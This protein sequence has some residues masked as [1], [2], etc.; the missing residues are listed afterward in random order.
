MTITGAA[1]IN[2]GALLS[3]NQLTTPT[4][5][6]YVLATAASGGLTSG[7]F[8][9]SG[10]LPTGYQ[11]VYN[12][13]SLDL[14]HG[15]TQT[16]TSPSPTTV[17]IITGSSTTVSATLSNTA[18][19][20]SASLTVSL[21]D[22]GSTG[23]TL[24]SFTGSGPIAAGSSTTVGA[25][26]TAGSVGTGLTW[27][28]SNTDAGAVPTT[29]STGGIVNVYNHSAAQLNVASGN[30]QSIIT[31]GAFGAATAT[32]DNTTAT[33]SVN[34]PAPLDVNTL[35]NLTGSTGSAVVGSN[36][37]G[38]YTAT[39]ALNANN[40]NVGP[41]NT[42]NVGI[43]AGDSAT[44]VGANPL[45]PL[46][47]SFTYNVYGHAAPSLTTGTLNLGYIHAGYASPVA[48]T[49]SLSST[50]G[51]VSDY[52]VN[53]AGSAPAIGS[54][55][56]NPIAGIAPG[57]AGVISATLGT[58]VASGTINDSFTY[59]FGDSS[60]LSGS[61]N[62]VGTA[63]IAVQGAVYSGSSTWNTNGGGSWGTLA[64]GFGANWGANQGSPGLDPSFVSTDSATFDNTALTAGNSAT[65]TLDG[66]SPHLA[67][68]TFNTPSGGGYTIAQGSS[69]RIHLNGGGSGANVTVL[70]GTDVI[71]APIQL[72]DNTTMTVTNAADSLT[73]SGSIT[74]GGTGKNLT[75][76]GAGTLILSGSDGYG[77]ATDVTGGTLIVS[78]SLTATS[79]LSV[80]GG[81]TA[82]LSSTNDINNSAHVTLNN[83]TLETLAN[84]SETLGDLALGAGGGTLS[85]GATGSVLNFA[86]SSTDT[87]SGTLAIDNWN[88]LST[89]GG[90]DEIFIGTTADLTPTQL[91]DITFYSG[92]V[93]GNPFDASPAAQLAD[94]EIIAAIPEPGTWGMLLAGMG[95]L[96]VWQRSR[97]NR[98]RDF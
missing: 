79:A 20:G 27:S 45:S 68:I 85:L 35:N 31:G 73:A 67:A 96:T 97:R 92:S 40:T 77:G 23:G 57:S 19:A 25:T 69:G 54:D 21:A 4:L 8:T 65:V 33:T 1:T 70:S 10:S 98:R 56:L 3:F 94:G 55:S 50:N 90:T 49:N 39:A 78:G 26:L 59:T 12:G 80:S 58:G 75:L 5:G 11:L 30:N 48:S 83:G 62:N 60:T 38:T 14:T 89:G 7:P 37:T 86:D 47:T 34:T 84:Q 82:E 9:V 74:D 66:A 16:L 95:M 88:G 81:G 51:S 17:L 18:P 53:M 64:S 13:T 61:R 63:T 2:S 71:S 29:T 24:G 15:E 72:N 93:D 41:G 42:L 91:A 44:V 36:S 46:S 43:N 52:R 6:N 76:D 32:L 87:W 22:N 28:L